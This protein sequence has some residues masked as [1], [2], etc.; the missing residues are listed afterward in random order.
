M[1]EEPPDEP[2]GRPPSRQPP[3]EQPPDGQPPSGFEA[4]FTCYHPM[5]RRY[6]LWCEAEYSVLEDAAQLTMMAALTYWERVG[7][8]DDPRGWLFKVAGQRLSHVRR[9][10]RGLD[11]VGDSAG[12]R[13][14][15]RDVAHDEVAASDLRLDVLDA[16]RKLPARQQEALAMQLQFDMGYDEIA[17]VMGTTPGTVRSHVHAARRTLRSMLG[18]GDDGDDDHD[19][20]D[21]DAE[22]DRG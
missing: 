9:E 8:M 13:G 1:S 12:L 4:F 3:E 6:L 10:R 2:S 19:G 21:R 5:V 15:A 16:I 17:D 11:L 20:G 18:D 14:R 22:G 7:P